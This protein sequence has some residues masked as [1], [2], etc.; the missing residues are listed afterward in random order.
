MSW[1]FNEVIY[2]SITVA[3]RASI[4]LSLTRLIFCLNIAEKQRICYEKD[5]LFDWSC[6]VSAYEQWETSSSLN[7]YKIS[8]ADGCG[9]E[10]FVMADWT[11][12]TA[13]VQAMYQAL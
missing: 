5:R 13:I 12:V 7:F 3:Y 1:C 9:Y 2:W 8:V 4:T 6:R 11:D 10:L